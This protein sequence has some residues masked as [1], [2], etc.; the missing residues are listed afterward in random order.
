MS[1]GMSKSIAFPP[2][3]PGH[4]LQACPS[5]ARWQPRPPGEFRRVMEID[6]PAA[7]EKLAVRLAGEGAKLV[8]AQ[9]LSGGASMHTWAFDIDT[10]DGREALILRRRAAPFDPD[11]ARS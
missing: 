3:P 8:Q 2:V 5:P 7:L 6:V 11:N 10:P 4:D 1:W 9:R